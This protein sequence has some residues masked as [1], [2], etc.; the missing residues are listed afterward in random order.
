MLTRGGDEVFEDTT[1]FDRGFIGTS[2]DLCRD[3]QR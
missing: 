3:V 2:M 1:K